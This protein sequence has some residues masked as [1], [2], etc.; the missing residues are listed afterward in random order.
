MNFFYNSESDEEWS[1]PK[2]KAMEKGQHISNSLAN[3]INLACST[4][5]DIEEII[6]YKIYNS[7]N[8]DKACPPIVNAEVWRI[9]DRKGHAS[10]KGLQDLQAILTAA[11]VPIIKL[12]KMVKKSDVKVQ[13]KKYIADARLSWVKCNTI[14]LLNT[15][16][17]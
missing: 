13:C 16:M 2:T 6:K 11:M 17:V 4:P 7:W 14:F 3:M 10:D 15:D 5:C 1:P 9:M 12:A 8:F